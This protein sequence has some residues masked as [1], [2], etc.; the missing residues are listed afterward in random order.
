MLQWIDLNN[1]KLHWIYRASDFRSKSLSIQ[2]LK[3]LVRPTLK[4]AE[5]VSHIVPEILG[6]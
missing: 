1:S 3:Q 5:N 2:E 6:V 4:A